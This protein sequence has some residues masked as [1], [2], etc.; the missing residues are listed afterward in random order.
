[1]KFLLFLLLM[2]SYLLFSRRYD[3]SSDE[4]GLWEKGFALVYSYRGM[5]SIVVVRTWQK[6]GRAWWQELKAAY[7][8]STF[9]KQRVSQL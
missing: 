4:I 6:A 7:I 3:K 9:R 1:M 5:R 2:T 8:V